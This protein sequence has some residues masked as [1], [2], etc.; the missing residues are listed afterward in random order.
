MNALDAQREAAEYFIR[1]MAGEGWEALPHRYDDGGF[2]GASSGSPMPVEGAG[3]SS[4][5]PSMAL[6]TS[7]TRQGRV[8]IDRAPSRAA[9]PCQRP[10]TPRHG[11]PMASRGASCRPAH[12]KMAPIGIR[13]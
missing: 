1:A 9:R 11:A 8:S 4:F 2:T 10:P 3:C 12:R 13:A 5:S 6:S 7:R